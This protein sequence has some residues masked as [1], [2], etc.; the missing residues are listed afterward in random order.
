MRSQ[1]WV[2]DVI[3][4]ACIAH[5]CYKLNLT[6]NKQ[7]LLSNRQTFLRWRVTRIQEFNSPIPY[8]HLSY[9]TFPSN[10]GSHS[11]PQL[12]RGLRCRRSS[13]RSSLTVQQRWYLSFNNNGAVTKMLPIMVIKK[14][15]MA[16]KRWQ[17]GIVD[18]LLNKIKIK[19]MWHFYV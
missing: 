14:R 3:I 2:I 16:V 18:I 11:S 5:V 19:L 6:V 7:V 4:T 8:R 13:G 15:P 17:S 10:T 9:V 1:G 12:F